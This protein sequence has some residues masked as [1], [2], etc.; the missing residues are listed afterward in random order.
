MKRIGVIGTMVWDKI[1][2]RGPSLQP[3][4][5]WGGIAY[6]LAALE[7]S[8]PTDWEIVPL[9][10]VGR[11][12][13]ARANA[14]LSALSKRAGAARFVE[15]PEPNNRVTLHYSSAA[16][17]SEHLF[18][19]VPPWTWY[20]LGPMVRDLDVVYLNFISGF[21]LDLEAAGQ[22]R[23][24]FPGPIYA[25]LHSLLLGV[26][27]NGLRTPRS[28]PSVREWL[29]C[30]DV[31][32]LN[33]EELALIG[34]DPL[35][36]AADALA[37]GVRLLLVTLGALGAVYFTAPPFTLF[38]HGRAGAEQRPIRTARVP[39]AGGVE[40]QDPTGCGDVF[41]ATLIAHLVAD[42]PV[43]EAIALA[44]VAAGRSAQYHGATNLHYHLRGEIV[45]R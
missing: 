28:L 12:M 22:L 43:E 5:E 8:L 31:V 33:E 42:K 15:V 7:A 9:V 11:D 10:K 38:S 26:Q 29:T 14:F 30:F 27:C 13:S 3:V 32:Q 35:A 37:Q 39:A 45:P 41:G 20:E 34:E 21:E 6:A 18:G 40:A 44:N 19:G 23:R 16:R 25:D 2:G 4:E 24:G 1:Y 36:V 17:R